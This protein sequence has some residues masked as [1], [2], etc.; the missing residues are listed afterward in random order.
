MLLFNLS[1]LFLIISAIHLNTSHVIVQLRHFLKKH[2][3]ML[4]LNTSHVIVQPS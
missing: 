2:L 1:I 3:A 4:N